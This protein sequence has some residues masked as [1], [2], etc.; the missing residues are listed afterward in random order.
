MDVYLDDEALRIMDNS[1]TVVKK[2]RNLLISF[3]E[4]IE[5]ILYGLSNENN[6]SSSAKVQRKRFDDDRRLIRIAL[7]ASYIRKYYDR[8]VRLA[9]KSLMM[10]FNATSALLCYNKK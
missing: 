3:V 1:K 8:R 9:I 5:T 2:V 4:R 6:Y 7:G 10:R